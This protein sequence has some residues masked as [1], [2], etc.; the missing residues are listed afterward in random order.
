MYAYTG[1]YDNN[2][3]GLLTLVW[4]NVFVDDLSIPIRL[5]VLWMQI[6]L[7]KRMLKFILNN[8]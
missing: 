7:L 8:I 3:Q 2:L 6:S 4:L 1:I 5:L